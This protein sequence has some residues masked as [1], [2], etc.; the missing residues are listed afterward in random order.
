[1]RDDLHL[2]A[3]QRPDLLRQLAVRCK[4]HEHPG[5]GLRCA[6]GSYEHLVG[7]GTE[8]VEGRLVARGRSADQQALE[9][10]GALER[11]RH[12]RCQH[13]AAGIQHQHQVRTDALRIV[14]C[15]REDGGRVT[16]GHRLAEAEVSRQHCHAVGQLAGAK[17]DEVPGQRA[18]GTQLRG[19]TRLD[20]AA[21]VRQH[22][23][24]RHSLGD[25]DQADDQHEK[26]FTETT[27][28]VGSNDLT[29]RRSA[30]VHIARSKCGNE[31][32]GIC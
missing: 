12:G 1:M 5:D 25:D 28:E 16:A 24:Q 10:A 32:S 31:T 26:P 7:L 29:H 9:R 6:H 3:D 22:C 15:G 23:G 18:T 4:A 8:D 21:R 30:T 27:H 13:L 14:A 20:G 17:A 11:L 19:G 2:G